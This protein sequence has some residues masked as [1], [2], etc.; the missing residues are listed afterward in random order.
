MVLISKFLIITILITFFLGCSP[1]MKESTNLHFSVNEK[2]NLNDLNVNLYM[3]KKNSGSKWYGLLKKETIIS[4][5]KL[6]K[7]SVSDSDISYYEIYVFT[8]YSVKM[9]L[10]DNIFK[11]SLMEYFYSF[12]LDHMDFKINKNKILLSDGTL[13]YTK[14]FKNSLVHNFTFY[15]SNTENFKLMDLGP[16]T[17]SYIDSLTFSELLETDKILTKDILKLKNLSLSQKKQLIE[18]HKMKKFNY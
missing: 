16:D 5:G 11:D 8:P 17:L 18:V 4:N 6:I 13:Y 7:S 3:Y 15:D 14:D 9:D 10:T 12:S 2:I 1:A